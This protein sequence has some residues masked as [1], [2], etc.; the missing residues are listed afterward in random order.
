MGEWLN[1]VDC[2]S[3]ASGYVSSNLTHSTKFLKIENKNII[4]YQLRSGYSQQCFTKINK[5]MMF[6]IFILT[7]K[8]ISNI[9]KTLTNQVKQSVG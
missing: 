3:T 5:I 4:I 7:G 2:K 6:Y 1:P 9:I 8:Y